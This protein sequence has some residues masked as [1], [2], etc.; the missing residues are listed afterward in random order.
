MSPDGAVRTAPSASALAAPLRPVLPTRPDPY[1]TL[2]RPQ[3]G[4]LGMGQPAEG[5]SFRLNPK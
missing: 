5:V 2:G 3:C 1:P 4:D